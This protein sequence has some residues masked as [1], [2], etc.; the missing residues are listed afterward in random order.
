MLKFHTKTL[1]STAFFSFSGHGQRPQVSSWV[2][3]YFLLSL[4][5]TVVVH[6]I[7]QWNSRNSEKEQRRRLEE[8][9]GIQEQKPFG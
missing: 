2:W 4:I 9:Y 5:L 1:F 3:I 6:I 7:W 8:I